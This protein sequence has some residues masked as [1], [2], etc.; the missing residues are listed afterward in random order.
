MPNK[1]HLATKLKTAKAIDL[2]IPES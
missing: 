1:F 2:K